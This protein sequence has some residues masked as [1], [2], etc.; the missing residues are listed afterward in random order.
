[1][2][3]FSGG[4]GD[5]A[6]ASNSAVPPVCDSPLSPRLYY[7]IGSTPLSPLSIAKGRKPPLQG[8]GDP[9]HTKIAKC[10]EPTE[11]K[12]PKGGFPIK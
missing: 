3:T 4:R 10:A 9:A 2:V 8:S 5:E 11:P 6:D 1:M 7:S 12:G